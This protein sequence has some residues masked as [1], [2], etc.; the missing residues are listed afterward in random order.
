MISHDTVN[1][2]IMMA[3][4]LWKH[5]VLLD[6]QKVNFPSTT[7]CHPVFS[8]SNSNSWVSNSIFGGQFSSILPQGRGVNPSLM[9]SSVPIFAGPWNLPAIMPEQ[10]QH[11]A[12]GIVSRQD[13]MRKDWRYD[14]TFSTALAVSALLV[15]GNLE[16]HRPF[17]CIS[18]LRVAVRPGRMLM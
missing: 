11:E 4:D 5:F 13:V 17:V 12:P 14:F 15:V 9:L 8:T 18:M 3:T 6:Y 1:R 2:C 10:E 16:K 7:Y